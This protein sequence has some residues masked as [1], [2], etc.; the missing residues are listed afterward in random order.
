MKVPPIIVSIVCFR[1]YAR[2][3]IETNRLFPCLTF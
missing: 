3:L 2:G 1:I